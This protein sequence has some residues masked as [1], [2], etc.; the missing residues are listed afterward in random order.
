MKPFKI[1]W[2]VY[3]KTPD[4]SKARKLVR[5]LIE[6]LECK[7]C[8]IEVLRD[9]RDPDQHIAHVIANLNAKTIQEAIFRSMRMASGL[10][11]RWDVGIPMESVGDRWEF[12]GLFSGKSKIPGIEWA[13]FETEN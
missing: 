12:D 3:L 10:A 4:D 5:R 9:H 6:A 8:S 2:K 13:M 1:R 7:S 11:L